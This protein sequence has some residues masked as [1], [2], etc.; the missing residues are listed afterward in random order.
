MIIT[1]IIVIHHDFQCHDYYHHH[2]HH[3]DSHLLHGQ[4]PLV[5]VASGEHGMFTEK[6]V[7]AVQVMILTWEAASGLVEMTSDDQRIMIYNDGA[8]DDHYIMM[9]FRMVSVRTWAR[10]ALGWIWRLPRL[11]MI[12]PRLVY[13]TAL[14]L[15][16]FSSSSPSPLSSSSSSSSSGW[17]KNRWRFKK[18]LKQAN[19]FLS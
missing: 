4:W 18:L 11:P 8:D 5:Q 2:C 1:N 9:S 3:Q 10:E 12:S 19:D 13:R 16:K 7:T 17:I 15:S 6:L 14:S